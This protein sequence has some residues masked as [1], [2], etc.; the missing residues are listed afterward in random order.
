MKRHVASKS[1]PIKTTAPGETT[2]TPT[3]RMIR[4][5]GGLRGLDG[6]E[7]HAQVVDRGIAMLG[8]EDLR[9]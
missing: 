5:F 6:A 9:I 4:H 3:A 2:V 1:C 7:G 8:A